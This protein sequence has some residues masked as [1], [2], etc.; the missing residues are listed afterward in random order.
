MTYNYKCNKCGNVKEI[1]IMTIDIMDKVGRVDQAKLEMRMYEQRQCECG[2]Q[3]KKIITTMPDTYWFDTGIG[4]G[5][6]SSRFK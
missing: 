4:K 3:L 5:K 1:S 2:G 6:I